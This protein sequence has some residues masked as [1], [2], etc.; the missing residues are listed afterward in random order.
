LVNAV[1][2]NIDIPNIYPYDEMV[3]EYDVSINFFSFNSFNTFILPQSFIN[4]SGTGDTR[5]ITIQHDYLLHKVGDIITISGALDY[6]DISEKDINKKHIITSINIDSFEITLKYINFIENVGSNNN[7]GNAIKIQCVNYFKLLFVGN[8]TI[9]K[10]FNFFGVGTTLSETNYRTTITNDTPYIF[11]MMG[12]PDYNLKRKTS[13][14]IDNHYILLQSV[15]MNHCE[16]PFQH[17]YFY[18]FNLHNTTYNEKSNV[19]LNTFVDSPFIAQSPIPT[20]NK[21]LFTFVNYNGEKIENDMFSYS[22]TLEIITKKY[23]IP[24]SINND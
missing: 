14:L 8:N 7:G 2:K 16:N 4:C 19:L 12:S 20:I 24:P 15:N 13:L 10:I 11:T 1:K 5:I 6:F 21:L 3:I 23:I 17:N 22:M 9:G 18:K